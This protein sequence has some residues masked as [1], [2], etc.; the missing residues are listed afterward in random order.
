MGLLSSTRERVMEGKRWRENEREMTRG[1]EQMDRRR[2]QVA[3][4]H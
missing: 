3:V 2:N 1:P 4:S